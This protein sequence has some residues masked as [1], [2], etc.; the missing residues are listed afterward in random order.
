[1]NI[2]LIKP[3][4][5][6][7]DKALE[8]RQ[9]HFDNQEYVIHGSNLFDEIDLYEEW[10]SMVILNS[11]PLTVSPDRVVSDV[12]FAF[13][14][15]RNKIVGIIDFRHTLNDFLLDFGHCGY[16]VRPSERFKGIASEMLRLLLIVAKEEGLSEIILSSKQSNPASIKTIIKNGDILIRTFEYDDE[17]AN[18]YKITLK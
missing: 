7:K 5:N 1:M 3:T 13:D 14:T 17:V 9:E 18:V 16:S 11:N 15:K 4:I 2:T 6:L 10:L 12:F 8:Y